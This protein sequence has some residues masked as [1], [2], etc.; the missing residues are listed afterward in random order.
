MSGKI[1]VEVRIGNRVLTISGYESEEYLQ[2]VATYINK[3]FAEYADDDGF[4]KLNSDM[5]NMLLE[6]NIADDYFK[7]KKQISLLEE[8]VK[9]K[10]KEIYDLKHDLTNYQVRL[11]NH[12]KK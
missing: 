2:K 8:K 9:E 6:I 4:R 1:D 12:G 5:Q 11:A 7:A 3:K 10:E